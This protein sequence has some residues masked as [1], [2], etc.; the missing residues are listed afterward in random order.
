MPSIFPDLVKK[1]DR[2][3]W[4]P[5]LEKTLVVDEVAIDWTFHFCPALVQFLIIVS[6]LPSHNL[7]VG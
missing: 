6:I 5:Y 3:W 2:I 4:V 1:F 7:A